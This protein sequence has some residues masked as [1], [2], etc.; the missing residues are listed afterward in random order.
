MSYNLEF[1]PPPPAHMGIHY[2]T[3]TGI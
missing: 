1:R 3:K 2:D